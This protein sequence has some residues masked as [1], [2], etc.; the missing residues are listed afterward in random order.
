MKRV[1]IIG[2]GA[3]GLTAALY[4]KKNGAQVTVFERKDR[5]G[6]KILV[7]GNG[8]CNFSNAYMKS[9]C[10]YTDDVGFVDRVLQNYSNN[11]LCMFFTGLGLLIK[12][13]NGYFYPACEQASAVLDVI[14]NAID[15]TDIEVKTECLV[16]EVKATGDGYIVKT[17][18]GET[19]SFDSIVMAT[20]GKAGLPAKEEANGY[21]IL[22]S[23]G[24]KVTK[25][26]PSLT[27]I[28]CEGANFKALSGVR[29][30]CELFLFGGEELVMKQGGEVLFTDNGLSGIVSF[31]V[32]HCVAKLLDEKKDV[33]IVLN[34][35][36]GFERENLKNFVMSKLLLHENYTVE[37]FF[38]GFLNKK[39]NIEIIKMCGLKPSAKVGDCSKEA[40]IDAV[41]F[42]QE[43]AV[44][45]VGTNGYD[46]AQVTGGGVV[47][48]ELTDTLESRLH[49]GLY[50][51]GE[52]VDVDGICGGYN[53]Q[54][55]FS[56]GAIA[57]RNAS[58]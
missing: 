3:G 7:T 43:F 8:R 54:W 16:T 30:D 23:L 32:S 52:L 28:K 21:D 40:I 15:E 4:A 10:Y 22:K 25:L 14:R 57:G 12:E 29:D 33:T 24:H 19:F 9:D 37:N 34:L 18:S 11:D 31:Q 47:I 48:N 58:L 2:G 17:E 42:M 35:L 41:L 26:Y 49:K 36:P 56:T 51:I 50:V 53:L 45:A 46:K 5:I 20:G 38:T 27:Q 13:K 39:L 55:A 6:K 1:G 44:K